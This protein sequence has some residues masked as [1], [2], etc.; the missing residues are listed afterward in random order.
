[1]NLIGVISYNG[2]DNTDDLSVN[3]VRA[4]PLDFGDRWDLFGNIKDFNSFGHTTTIPCHGVT[5]SVFGKDP[6]CTPVA[7][8]NL[9]PQACQTAATSLPTNPSVPGTDPK[10]TGLK[11]LAA[12]GCYISGSSVIVRPAQGT[13]GNM[14]RNMFRGA[15]L[16]L[17]DLSLRKKINV[18]RAGGRRI[19]IPN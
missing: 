4:P 7:N 8:V 3:L 10:S 18:H 5:G 15:G 16:R 2:S 14:N 6:A 1:M 17:G 12:L 19:P 13:F 9:M 11:S